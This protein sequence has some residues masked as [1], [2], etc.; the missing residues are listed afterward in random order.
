MYY[1]AH[2]KKQNISQVI[3][4]I[5]EMTMFTGITDAAWQILQKNSMWK[6]FMHSIVKMMS[7]EYNKE[8]WQRAVADRGKS[9]DF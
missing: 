3:L 2:I 9:G 1:S 7:L 4:R 6:F 8:D 5:I